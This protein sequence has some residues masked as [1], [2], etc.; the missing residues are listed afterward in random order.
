[1]YIKTLGL[2]IHAQ[3]DTKTKLFSRAAVDETSSPNENVDFL[4]AGLPGALPVPNKAAIYMAMKTCLAL[5]MTVNQVSIF[6]RKHYFYQDLP[7]GY[8]ITQFYKPIGVAGYLDFSFGRVRIN[9]L[10]IECDAG[11]SIYKDN[12][13]YVDL[14]RAGVPLMEIVTE[15]DFK[16]ED[17]VVEFI[18]E[19]RG[20]LLCI[21][22]CK[23]D[24]EM[25]NLRADVNLSLSKSG[26]PLGTRV[27]IKNLN[28]FSSIRKAVQYEALLQEKVLSKGGIIN[29][30]TKL[31]DPS[32]NVTKVMRSKEEATD[33]QYFPD[34]DLLPVFIS[35]DKIEECRKSLPK[36]PAEIRRS[37]H[38]LGIADEQSRT[39]TETMDRYSFF[40]ELLRKIDLDMHR[41]GN[42]LSES[43][44][45]KVDIK[46]DVKISNNCD[47]PVL[48]AVYGEPKSCVAVSASNWVCSELI[49]R[50]TKLDLELET[51]LSKAKNFIDSFA[52]I[53]VMC[54]SRE[55]TRVIA[56]DMLDK[57][58]ME[59]LPFSELV[60]KYGF[61]QK[62][63]FDLDSL[64]L[65]LLEES[66]KEVD[67]Y[68][69]GKASIV[70]YFVGKI[71]QATRGRCDAEE[72]RTKIIMELKR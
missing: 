18:K 12:R 34:P 30:E 56:K 32:N 20:I 42:R 48:K 64:I 33:Y 19:L 31:F 46:E 11:K 25:G 60:A 68:K 35:E 24:M 28:S 6:D 58:I 37:L 21:K 47:E 40:E 5:N 3:I 9:R 15:P 29:S 54:E 7:L 61:L 72:V 70:M 38:M 53:I 69:K 65:Q 23:C 2:E 49:G 22:T 41:A 4:D 36:L 51:F 66:P 13:T 14:N 8:Q 59:D 39:L 63:Q 10:H 1:M 50:L 26:E 57:S 27:E 62:S 52:K 45:K 17:Q 67:K 55:V 71:M 43:F 44:A 16:N